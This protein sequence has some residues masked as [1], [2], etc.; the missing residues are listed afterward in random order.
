[1][2]IEVAGVTRFFGST[3]AVWNMSMTVP[4]GSVTGLVGPNGAGKTTLLLMLAA[5]LAPD[6][7]TIRIAGLDPLTQPRQVHQAV[8]WMPD[9][10]GTWD[11]LTCTEILMTF[12]TAQGLDEDTG[13]RNTAEMLAA[14]HLGEMARTPARVLSR[15]GPDEEIGRGADNFNVDEFGADFAYTMDGGPVGELE[16]ESFNAAGAVFKIKGKSVHPGTA[17][18]KMINASLITAEI[19]NSFPADEVPEK[20]EGYEG[21]YFLEKINANCEDA[22]L[23]YI[24]RDHD[25]QKFEEKKKFAE[26]VAKKINEKY[27]KELVTVEIKDQY[28]NMG[29]IIKNHMEIVEIAK[30]A[31]E[32][33]EIKPIIKPIR[34]GT[35]GSKISFMGL[36]T[37]NIF[38]GGENF[39]GKY[40][41]VALESMILATDVIVEIVRLNAEGE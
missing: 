27:K 13:L 32:N 31:M 6:G 22:E 37:P 36:P 7:G 16:Y 10:F 19:I 4:A 38:A 34:G 30:K 17:K 14:V 26:N 25:R 2:S 15:G 24:L 35:D 29:E 40:E 8:G 9:A 20:T 23:S 28:Y 12:A 11:S 33:L 21:F 1:M 41:F 39:H 18:G 5:L 3:R